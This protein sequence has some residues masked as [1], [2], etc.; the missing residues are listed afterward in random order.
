MGK[1]KVNSD[2]TVT[3]SEKIAKNGR[4]QFD[5][6]LNPGSTSCLVEVKFV[7]WDPVEPEAGTIK[8][9]S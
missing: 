3:G 8:I 4:V 2:G 6:D 1:I 9:G 5:V 7:K